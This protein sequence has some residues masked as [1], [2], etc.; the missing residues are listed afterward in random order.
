M[1]QW[2]DN[3]GDA[4]IVNAVKTYGDVAVANNLQALYTA[5]TC[6]YPS[7]AVPIQ[8]DPNCAFTCYPPY[9]LQSG[10]CVLPPSS[11]VTKKKRDSKKN[12]KRDAL[13][14]NDDF[15]GIE[16]EEDIF[17]AKCEWGFTK[18]GI[19]NSEWREDGLGFECVDT[20]SDL[21]SC[22]GCAVPFYS[23]HSSRPLGTDC[24]SIPGVSDVECVR[25]ACVVKRCAKGWDVQPIAGNPTSLECIPKQRE[26]SKEF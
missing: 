15:S 6:S 18:C 13:T 19:L 25:G 24:T 3:S 5:H 14:L 4:D 10:S 1:L 26:S 16:K 23:S 11:G 21:E 9:V 20:S 2:V 22:G 12:A 7:Y 8:C 17:G